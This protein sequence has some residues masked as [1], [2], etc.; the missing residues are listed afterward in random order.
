MFETFLSRFH[1]DTVFVLADYST[2]EDL[3][4]Q[5][6]D[7][8]FITVDE[9]VFFHERVYLARYICESLSEIYD[10]FGVEHEDTRAQ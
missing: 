1:D 5:Y 4:E 8:L 7:Y 3:L 6:P 9:P 10:F 2:L